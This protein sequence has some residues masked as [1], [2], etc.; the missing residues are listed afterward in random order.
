MGKVTALNTFLVHPKI[1]YIEC[2]IK[3]GGA[4]ANHDHAALFAD[5]CRHRERRLARVF[6]HH[7]DV[8]ALA[9]DVPDR[10][11]EFTRFLEPVGVFGGVDGGQLAPALEIL[12]VDDTLGAQPH[13]KVAFV[14]VRNHANGV[15]ACRVDQLDRIRSQTAGR[16]PNQHVLPR[17]QI[18]RFMTEQHP[19]SRGQRQCVT[20]A[21]FPR[22]MLRAR[23]Q[24]LG[25]HVCEL[26]ERSIRGFVAPNALAGRKHRVAA[27]AFFVV[28]V[29]LVAMHHDLV[30]DFPAFHFIAHGPNDASS[31]GSCNMVGC[32][33]AVKRANRLTETCPNTVV[34]YACRHH[35]DQ[36]FVAIQNGRID[37]F[38]LEGLIGLAVAFAPDRPCIHLRRDVAHW[39]DFTHLIE[40]FFL[41]LVGEGCVL[42]ES[43][44][45]LHQII[46]YSCRAA[47]TTRSVGVIPWRMVTMQ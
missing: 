12:A 37:H 30:A 24:L 17:F 38:N 26:C 46:H 42:V 18:V 33:V 3:A 45:R 19:V 32:A 20:R 13:D 7:I 22:Q 14:F 44:V 11:A 8:V 9:G 2:A 1:A 36:H 10:L 40:V 39:R 5:Q 41:C 25:L 27:V 15:G 21:F 35:E 6:E 28:A 31:V 23:H 29:V 43:H 4:R 47:E 16:A 34:I